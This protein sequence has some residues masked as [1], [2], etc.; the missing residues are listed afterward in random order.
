VK[1]R[2]FQIPEHG[3][4]ITGQYDPRTRHRGRPFVRLGGSGHHLQPPRL[5]RESYTLR[6]DLTRELLIAANCD[7][8]RAKDIT[9]PNP[10][11]EERSHMPKRRSCGESALWRFG[12]RW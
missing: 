4:E 2:A 7:A 3:C 12:Q 10:E 5:N 6:D 9:G 1:L 11:L 8:G